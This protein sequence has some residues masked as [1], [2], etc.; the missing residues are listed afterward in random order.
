MQ[1]P[2]QRR[3]CGVRGR[4]PAADATHEGLLESLYV[5]PGQVD[6]AS[7]VELPKPRVEQGDRM[8]RAANTRCDRRRQLALQIVE[9]LHTLLEG[10]TGMCQTPHDPIQ[11]LAA[12]R[13]GMSP[14][15]VQRTRQS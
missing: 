13:Q 11:T 12:V 4:E 2:A 5:V 3:S 15:R 1:S 8:A 14:V 7:W 6:F 10:A 9:P